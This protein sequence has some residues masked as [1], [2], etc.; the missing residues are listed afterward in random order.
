MMQPYVGADSG[1]A[2][3]VGSEPLLGTYRLVPPACAIVFASATNEPSEAVGS[4]TTG[5]LMLPGPELSVL[6]E[7]DAVEVPSSKPTDAVMLPFAC[8]VASFFPGWH[9]VMPILWFQR[10]CTSPPASIASLGNW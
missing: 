4:V 7:P 6:V 9:S 2:N 5:V 10:P 8:T 1:Q 3:V